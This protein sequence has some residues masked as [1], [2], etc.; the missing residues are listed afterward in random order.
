MA[1]CIVVFPP[2]PPLHSS[3]RTIVVY[4]VYYRRFDP[5]TGECFIFWEIH[6]EDST[7][8][9]LEKD[10]EGKTFYYWKKEEAN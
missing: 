8:V 4:K 6:D 3:F 1:I 9:Y 2:K 10:K 7:D 5:K